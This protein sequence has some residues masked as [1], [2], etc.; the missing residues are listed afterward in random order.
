MTHH[1]TKE[2]RASYIRFENVEVRYGGFSSAL[3]EVNLEIQKGEFV[4]IVGETGAGKSTLLKLLTREI[5]QTSGMVWFQGKD[6]AKLKRRSIPRLRREMGI[7]PQDP[8]LLPNKRVWENIGYAVRVAG[9]TR[10]QVRRVVPEILERVSI[11]HRADAFPHEL[12]GGEQHRVAIARA[13]VNNPTLLLADEPT[14]HLDSTH[15]LEIMQLLMQL[16]LRG[17]TV[18]VSTHD[19][20]LVEKLGKRMV[21]LSGG[22]IIAD[23]VP[24]A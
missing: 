4:F 16:N 17:T 2:R 21:V 13:L 3:Y 12:S 11:G 19:V 1:I 23:H 22:R 6:L 15:S 24:P 5:K 20:Q 9:M 18:I 8:S 7:V 10:R 14:A